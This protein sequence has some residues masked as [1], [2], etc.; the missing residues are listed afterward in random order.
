MPSSRLFSP[1]RDQTQVSY[2]SC[3]GRQALYHLRHLGSPWRQCGGSLNIENGNE[4]TI[5]PVDL[6]NIHNLK[7]EDY[8]LFS[9]NFQDFMHR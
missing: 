5:P 3:V 1:H 2:V 9:R 6:K 8:V 4:I 7:D